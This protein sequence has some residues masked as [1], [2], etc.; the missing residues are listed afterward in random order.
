MQEAMTAHC[1][2]RTTCNLFLDCDSG[3]GR[4]HQFVLPLEQQVEHSL[5]GALLPHMDILKSINMNYFQLVSV[6]LP[7]RVESLGS[8]K[9]MQGMAGPAA[10]KMLQ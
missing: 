6:T 2:L 8:Y 10:L 1:L 5:Q 9:N 7:T 4:S 3:G